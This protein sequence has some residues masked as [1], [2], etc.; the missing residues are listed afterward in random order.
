MKKTL[1]L[2]FVSFFLSFFPSIFLSFFLSIFLSF[3]LSFYL[4]LSLSF[5][6]SFFLSLHPLLISTLLTS[7]VLYQLSHQCCPVRHFFFVDLLSLACLSNKV[8]EPTE[9]NKK[10]FLFQKTFFFG[11]GGFAPTKFKQPGVNVIKLFSFV[12]DNG[13]Q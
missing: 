4:S 9:S 10:T 7:S 13:T 11:N 8:M 2:F 5:F 1:L 3:F 12:T 6:L